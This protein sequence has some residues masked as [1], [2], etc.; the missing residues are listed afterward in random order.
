MRQALAGD[1][2]PAG[3]PAVPRARAPA[4]PGGPDGRRDRRLRAAQGRQRLPPVLHLQDGRALRP[5]S[6]GGPRRPS[7]GSGGDP[8]GRRLHHAQR[9]QR[10]PQRAHHHDGGEGGRRDPGAPRAGGPGGARVPARHPGDAE[11]RRRTGAVWAESCE[12]RWLDG[13]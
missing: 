10:Q 12:R 8:R 9:C 4:G 3:L 13:V 7:A 6:R 1:L 2:R 5:R 11:M